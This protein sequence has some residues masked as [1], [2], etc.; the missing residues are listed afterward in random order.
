MG[1][2]YY[3][4]VGDLVKIGFTANLAKRLKAYPPHARL[5]A[6]EPGPKSLEKQRHR[7]LRNSLRQSNEWFVRSDEVT[8][9][10]AAVVAEH[11]APRVIR[12]QTMRKPADRSRYP[13]T[14]TRIDA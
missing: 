14:V 7:E 2:V 8:A 9:Q 12:P 3:L 11:G 4:L 13:V 5:L 10:I 6:V 1:Q